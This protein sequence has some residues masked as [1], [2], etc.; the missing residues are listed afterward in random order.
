METTTIIVLLRL[1]VMVTARLR[2]VVTDIVLR[3]RVQM[4]LTTEDHVLAAGLVLAAAP[5]ADHALAA[6]LVLTVAPVADRVLMAAPMADHILAADHVPAVLTAAEANV[7]KLAETV[8]GVKGLKMGSLA[9]VPVAI[10]DV[11]QH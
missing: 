10:A 6:G 9:A 8:A 5:M 3:R 7:R 2:P 1:P 4:D 11:R